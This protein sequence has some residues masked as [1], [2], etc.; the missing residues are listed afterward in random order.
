MAADAARRRLSGWLRFTGG[1]YALGGAGFLARP[2]D[3]IDAL[4]RVGDPLDPEP[5]GLYTSLSTAYMATIT[6]LALAAASAD[7][8]GRDHLIPPLLVAKATSSSALLFRYFKTRRLGY[9][10]GAALDAFLLGVTAGLHAA[11]RG[12]SRRS[13]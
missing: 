2:Q 7:D 3:A 6:A 10:A 12:D 9:A 11:A 1:I 8:D 4:G 13:R 5:P